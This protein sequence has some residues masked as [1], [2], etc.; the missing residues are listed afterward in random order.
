M[1]ATTPLAL[2]LRQGLSLAKALRRDLRPLY[3]QGIRG[4]GPLALAPVCYLA[5]V[6]DVDPIPGMP[7][8]RR[9]GWLERGVS[10]L[11][12][13]YLRSRIHC[14]DTRIAMC[15]WRGIPGLS[16]ACLASR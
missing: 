5:Y 4:E 3:P 14:R 9:L 15:H 2:K 8:T 12:T 11:Q 13:Q 7:R 6:L 16:R 1:S 10:A